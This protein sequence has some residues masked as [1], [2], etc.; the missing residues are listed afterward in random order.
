LGNFIE[1][2]RNG[3]WRKAA[4]APATPRGGALGQEGKIL[5]RTKP[6][7]LAASFFIG[8]ILWVI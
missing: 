4:T 6:I 2:S 8:V 5:R 3:P 7:G 1:T